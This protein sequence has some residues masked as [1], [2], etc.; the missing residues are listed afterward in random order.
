MLT[1]GTEEPITVAAVEVPAAGE[2]LNRPRRRRR[3][4]LWFRYLVVVVMVGVVVL[5]ALT[6]SPEMTG[7]LPDTVN[8]WEHHRI[9]G[10]LIDRNYTLGVPRA[11][12]AQRRPAII[13]L[14]A[15]LGERSEFIR[16]SDLWYRPGSHRGA[17]VAFPQALWGAWNSGPCCMPSNRVGVDD[18]AFLDAV[19]DELAARDDV[20]PER[21]Y[22]IGTSAGGLMAAHYACVTDRALA[23]VVSVVAQPLDTSGCEQRAV[24]ITFVL[25]AADDA[26]PYEGGWSLVSVAAAQRRAPPAREAVSEYAS[27]AGCESLGEAQPVDSK[28]FFPTTSETFGGCEQPVTLMRVEGM[29]H[30]WPWGYQWGPTD[31]LLEMIPADPETEHG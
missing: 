1:S 18:V 6:V 25:G 13:A 5:G 15:W 20:D 27:A 8:S 4:W 14:H 21:I 23:G 17:I 24:P 10:L 28:D 12:S 11:E 3:F 22:V 26:L 16:K 31:V 19:F 2:L 30:S 7:E 9:D 29:V